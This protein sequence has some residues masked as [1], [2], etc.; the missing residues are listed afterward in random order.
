MKYIVKKIVYISC[1]LTLFSGGSNAG[2][3]MLSV[4]KD[5]DYNVDIDFVDNFS[6]PILHNDVMK[7]PFSLFGFTSLESPANIANIRG[8]HVSG[9]HKDVQGSKYFLFDTAFLLGGGPLLKN[10]IIKCSNESCS[11]YTNYLIG[12]STLEDITIN[13]FT[14]DPDNGDIIF[15]IENA[16][17]INADPYFPA[18]LIRLIRATGT[19]TLE[20]DSLASIGGVTLGV[21]RNIDALTLLYDGTYLFSLASDGSV[22][23]GVAF[24]YN[25]SDILLMNP[26]K[27]TFDFLYRSENFGAFQKRVNITSLMATDNDLIFRNGFE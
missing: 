10:S 20:V 7:D 19:Y 5:I 18:D 26:T 22:S 27:G 3:P 23:G 21:N 6:E 16:G 25:K 24:A 12:D 2:S 14:L 13:A 17:A 4:L 9:Y 1:L 15:S 11:S 8:N